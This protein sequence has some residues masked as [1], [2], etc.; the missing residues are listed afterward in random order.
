MRFW[1]NA[2][3]LLHPTG[4]LPA[5]LAKLRKTFPELKVFLRESQTAALL[6]DLTTGRIDAALI[7]LPYPIND[8]KKVELFD[9]LFHLACPP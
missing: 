9:D 6:E 3:R 2:L 1:C 5:V 7:A 8:L 4:L